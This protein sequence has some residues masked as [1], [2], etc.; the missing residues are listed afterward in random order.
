M[1]DHPVKQYTKTPYETVVEIGIC[2]KQHCALSG[3]IAVYE[4]G[5]SDKAIATRFN[6][7]ES[8]VTNLRL[9]LIGELIRSSNSVVTTETQL[10]TL[11]VRLAKLET[12]MEK[13]AK[14]WGI[15]S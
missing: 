3:G 12:L 7:A 8:T 9:K 14:E 1:N 10:T 4:N 6:A 11:E 5:W 13:I 15:L 2:I